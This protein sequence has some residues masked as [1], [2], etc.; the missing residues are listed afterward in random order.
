MPDESA[1][2]MRLATYASVTVAVFL[3]LVI[4][5][6]NNKFQMFNSK[7]LIIYILPI[8]LITFAIINTIS[9]R[10]EENQKKATE[11]ILTTQNML[12]LTITNPKELNPHILNG[13]INF[14]SRNL[15]VGE[16]QSSQVSSNSKYIEL[17]IGEDIDGNYLDFFNI[18]NIELSE[19]NVFAFRPIVQIYGGYKKSGGVTTKTAFI[20]YLTTSIVAP[21]NSRQSLFLN[22]IEMVKHRFTC[23]I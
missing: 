17:Y 22:Q 19:E 9:L 13:Y 10:Q 7:E 5:S 21:Q 16:F 6:F 3:I 8:T 14:N 4:Q 2:L 23:M 12:E 18:S 11:N 15:S 20:E 1:R